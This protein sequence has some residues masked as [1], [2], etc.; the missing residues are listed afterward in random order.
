MENTDKKIALTPDGKPIFRCYKC[1]ECGTHEAGTILVQI[2]GF[3]NPDDF[4]AVRLC[5]R[6]REYL[7][8]HDFPMKEKF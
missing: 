1:G 7:R 2:D 5:S 4:H 3:K 6:C 8:S